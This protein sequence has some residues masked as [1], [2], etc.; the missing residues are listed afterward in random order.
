MNGRSERS[1]DPWIVQKVDCDRN[2]A[3]PLVM[4]LERC[5]RSVCTRDP[6]EAKKVYLYDRKGK[7]KQ[8]KVVLPP[9]GDRVGYGVGGS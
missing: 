6:V 3:I 1:W 9:E 4:L 2:R 5:D 7:R 8:V